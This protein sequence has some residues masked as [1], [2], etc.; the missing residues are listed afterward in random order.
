MGTGRLKNLAF[1]NRAVGFTNPAT[2][3]Q[4]P[5]LEL[6]VGDRRVAE[7]TGGGVD[8]NQNKNKI[9]NNK[10]KIFCFCFGKAAVGPK[11]HRL[12]ILVV[13][14]KILSPHLLPC[15]HSFFF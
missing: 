11:N 1:I 2:R 8:K 14:G 9:I 10:I 4:N 13:F 7:A 5:T 15:I 3:W 12:A 6:E